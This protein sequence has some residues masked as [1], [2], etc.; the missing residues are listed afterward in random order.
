M[1]VCAKC[2]ELIPISGYHL[3]SNGTPYSYCKPCHI[4]SCKENDTKNKEKYAQRKA[5]YRVANI[6][7]YRLKDKMYAETHSEKRKESQLKARI[8]RRDNGKQALDAAKKRTRKLNATPKWHTEW[9][10][11]FMEELYHIAKLRKMHVDHIVPLKGKLVC[12][13]HTPANLQLLTPYENMM[14]KNK[15][16]DALLVAGGGK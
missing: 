14:K 13:L 12:G 7:K 16:N 2:K 10:E 4:V 15:F 6:E 8:K 3:R 11:F 1:K 5:A 9:D